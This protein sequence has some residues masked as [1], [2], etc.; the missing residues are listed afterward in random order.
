MTSLKRLVPYL[1]P[2]WKEILF[3][4]VTMIVAVGSELLIPRQIQ[5][6][7]DDGIVASNTQVVVNASLLMGGLILLNMA[8]SFLRSVLAARVSEHTAADLR[9]A[10]YRNIQ[11]Y[12][13]ANLDHLQTGELLVRLTS[14]TN[15][16]KNAV[17]MSLR[18]A[19]RAPLL[20][21][22]S[23]IM[24]VVTSPRLALLLVVLLPL[25]AGMV[26]WFS[27]MSGPLFRRVQ[28]RLDRLNTVLQEN[29]AGVRVVRAF[30]REDY[31]NARFD[32]ANNA[33]MEVGTR[34]YQLFAL[35]LP[36][37]LLILNLGMAAILW[38]GGRLAID[39]QLTTGEIVAFTNYLMT[40]MFPVLMLGM[41][42]P[43]LYAAAVSVGRIVEVIDAAP[44]ITDP[45]DAVSLDGIRGRV[46]FENVTLDY[47][48][49][50][51]HHEP[52]LRGVDFVAEPGKTV[53]ILGATGSGKSSLVNLIPRFYDVT[54][55]RVTIDG[56]DVRDID[57]QTLRA[58]VGVA[59]QEAVLFSGSVRDN[60]RFGR[61]DA[62]D[63][64]VIAAAKAAQAHDFIMEK[65][66]G[67]DAQV[68]QRG[69][70][71]SGGEKQRIAIAR[72]LCTNPAIL[73]LDDSTSAVDVTTE[74]RILDRLDELMKE[75]TSFVVAQRISTV[76]SA[77]WII[78]L[79]N[80]QIAASGTH[81]ELLTSSPIYQEIYHSQL[82]NGLVQSGG[83]K[84]ASAAR[85]GRGDN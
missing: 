78:V 51:G 47:D 54:G 22:G 62:T 70:N 49:H 79:D 55:G 52:A 28:A 3:A 4:V 57:Q 56:V 12:T 83:A 39:G 31:E 81:Q 74:A 36:L 18:F 50:K 77:D 30:V 16:V 21:V 17:L 2:Y 84:P 46:A 34:T 45:P 24:L 37:M 11:R 6:I 19:L 64:E 73:I 7:I 72:A 33:Y 71:F 60:I 69:T 1:R 82:G 42:L 75:R 68:G 14:D 9:D 66:G 59:L 48:G 15:I 41:I 61:P 10:A 58:Q 44:A 20:L 35:L 80:G 67:Y 23:L 38:F 32:N 40:T 43:Q 63:E 85:T 29:I 53:A 26:T 13:F 5:H 8:V 25:T 27:S 76:L 65:P